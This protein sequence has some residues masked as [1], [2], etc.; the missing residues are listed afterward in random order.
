MTAP[1]SQPVT[2]DDHPAAAFAAPETPQ[3]G[4]P[5]PVADHAGDEPGPG[6]WWR[7]LVRPRSLISLVA[8]LVAAALWLGGGFEEAESLPSDPR[9]APVGEPVDVAPLTAT[10]LR[11]YWTTKTVDGVYY[12]A[13]GRR[14][15]L[16]VVDLTNTS[17][18]PV[19][20]GVQRA[21]IRTDATELL[22]W[23][24]NPVTSERAEPTFHRLSDG[25]G[26]G[27]LQPGLTTTTVMVWSQ[28]TTAPVPTQLVMTLHSHTWRESTL[29]GQE[30]WHDPV[31][32]AVVTVP[33][34]EL[35]P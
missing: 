5:G 32:V 29:T 20:V 26:G 11:A 27:A 30:G 17:D 3:P 4:E 34:K 22:D 23:T 16:L 28:A 14:G 1:P 18:A 15:L 33:V 8:A 2:P 24:G 10:V 12:R 9:P 25:L 31:A 19:P 21:A 7:S 13:E 35:Q 6:P